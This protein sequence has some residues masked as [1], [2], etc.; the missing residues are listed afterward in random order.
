MKSYL[1]VIGL[2]ALTFLLTCSTSMATVVFEDDFDGTT[3]DTSKWFTGGFGTIT[4]SDGNL[5]LDVPTG[6]WTYS[7][8][9]S[10][11]AWSTDND[12]YC[13]FTIGAI[14]EGNYNI[15]QVFEGTAHTGYVALRNDLGDGGWWFD[16]REGDATSA[17]YRGADQPEAAPQTLEVGDVITLKLGPDGSAAY[18]NGILFDSTE[19]VPQGDVVIDMQCWR[20]PGGVASQTF[21]RIEVS[22][23]AP[24]PPTPDKLTKLPEILSY[25]TMECTPIIWNGQPYLFESYRTTVTRPSDEYLA[26]KNLT[27]G[28]E[29][30]PF[31]EGYSL[32]CAYVEGNEIHVFAA[33]ESETAWF[34]DI[35]H[36][37]STDMV[38]WTKTLAIP[39]DNEHLLN[40]SVCE[41]PNGYIMAYET[42]NPVG[43]SFKF[44][45]STDLD[46]WTKLSVPAFAGASGTEYSACPVIRYNS[47]DDY[48]YV[49][50]LAQGQDE[51]AGEYVSNIIRSKDLI[52]W[53][54]SEENP[55]LYPTTGEGIN[56]S[57]V[58]LFELDGKTY[59]YYATGDQQ[60][61]LHL[62][63][64]VYDGTMSDFLESYFPAEQIAGDANGDGKVDGSDVTILAGNWQKG[65]SDGQTAIWEDGDF[66]G[67]GKVDGSDVTIL[68]GNWQ[69][70]V[71]T[72]S[73]S[74][75]E[76]GMLML[77]LGGML[78]VGLSYRKR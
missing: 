72:A 44:A 40:S 28:E 53:E 66:N 29:S 62:K 46:T 5:V 19:I 4:V 38:N 41:D 34:Q 15:M 33:E 67:D 21:D 9:D 7:Q 8:I 69:T 63:H 76:P 45:H 43:F 26:I 37:T 30:A 75:P 27:T 59:V 23:A 2:V 35:Y 13:S 22:G 14:P 18:K 58:D 1:C 71:T 64:A 10:T 74:V 65:V 57:D 24:I 16:V 12:I 31:G 20:E 25:N 73:A 17:T 61:W 3:L 52:D 50:Y 39:L 78:F 6:D 32:G 49:I 36:F 56:T 51:H 60:T 55:M 47:D 68:A 42:D 70:G 54:Y 11:S 77:L 48:Y